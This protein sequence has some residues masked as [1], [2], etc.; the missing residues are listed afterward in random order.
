ML[1][2]AIFLHVPYWKFR[3]EHELS[4]QERKLAASVRKMEVFSTQEAAKLCRWHTTEASVYIGRLANK[5]FVE[6]VPS[7]GKRLFRLVPALREYLVLRMDKHAMTDSFILAELRAK[8]RGSR[9]G[10]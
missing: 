9:K 2:G 8:P 6:R 5:G 4:A 10:K 1:E 7:I 3:I